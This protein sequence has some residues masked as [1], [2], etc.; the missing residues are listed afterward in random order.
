MM[1]FYGATAEDAA[2]ELTNWLSLVSAAPALAAP[3]PRPGH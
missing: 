2:R 1:P 3:T